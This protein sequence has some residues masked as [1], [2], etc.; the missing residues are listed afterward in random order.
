MSKPNYRTNRSTTE[1]GLRDSHLAS[2]TIGEKSKLNSSSQKFPSASKSAAKTDKEATIIGA[3]R[4]IEII[5][6]NPGLAPVDINATN[7]GGWSEVNA[8]CSNHS[9]VRVEQF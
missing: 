1:L 7:A 4:K 2:K 8:F 9:S 6:Y 3:S 5:A